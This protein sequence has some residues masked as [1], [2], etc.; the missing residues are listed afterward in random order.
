MF[1]FVFLFPIDYDR[2]RASLTVAFD[3]TFVIWFQKRNMKDVVT[4]H[5]LWELKSCD[6][7]PNK[8]DNRE[9]VFQLVTKLLGGPLCHE[10]LAIE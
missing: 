9:R 7:V 5:S 8:F 1:D 2:I 6:M 4:L 3:N 10:I